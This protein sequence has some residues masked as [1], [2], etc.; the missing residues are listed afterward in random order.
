MFKNISKEEIVV[1]A[2]MTQLKEI[3]DFIEQIGKKYKISDKITNSFKLVVDESCT[4]IIR[5]GYKEIK[6]GKIT[7]RAIIRRLSLTMIIIDQGKSFDP[8]QVKDPDLKKYVQIGKKGGLGIFM[9]RKLMDDMV[10]NFTSEGNELRLN[11]VREPDHEPVLFSWFNSLSLR[12]KSLLVTSAIMFIFTVAGYFILK[13]QIYSR[14]QTRVFE[15][16]SSITKEFA[17][18]NYDPVLNEED[19]LLFRNAQSIQQSRVEMIRFVM[20]LKQTREVFAVYPINHELATRNVN[21]D[22]LPIIEEYNV[23]R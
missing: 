13:S 4:N 17:E 3:R 23:M 19:L 6:D 8:R 10:Y 9:M 1:P 15:E 5:H 21:F 12:Y 16:A 14:I 18:M 2:S 7:I 22:N 20:I 11:K